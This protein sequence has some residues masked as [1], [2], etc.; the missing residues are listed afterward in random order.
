MRLC[1][2][3]ACST[4]MYTPCNC[5]RSRQQTETIPRRVPHCLLRRLFRLIEGGGCWRRGNEEKTERKV[6]EH[7]KESSVSV[8][9]MPRCAPENHMGCACVLKYT[10]STVGTESASR[11]SYN[12]SRLN[13]KGLPAAKAF[14]TS[15]LF[16]PNYI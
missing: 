4:I 14:K 1:C 9:E 5:P 7:R 3:V 15:R 8:C 13:G 2:V 12:S 6:D 16:Y 10:V 11:S